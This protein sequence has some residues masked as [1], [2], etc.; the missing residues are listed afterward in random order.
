VTDEVR[1]EE[2]EATDEVSGW[3]RTSLTIAV[4]VTTLAIAGVGWLEVRAGSNS[5]SAAQESQQFSVKTMSSL[6]QSQETT[7]V[8]YEDF[9][10]AEQDREQAGNALQQGIFSGAGN[11]AL[12]AL[13]QQRFDTLATKTQALTPLTPNSTDG[14]GKDPTFP[15]HAFARATLGADE[16]QALQDESNARESAWE[17]RDAKYTAVLTLLAVALYLFGL[18]LAMPRRVFSIFGGVGAVLLAI[19]VGWSLLI[20][21]SAPKAIPESAAADYANGEIALETSTIGQDP[22]GFQTSIVD[23]TKAIDEWPSFARA[24]LGRAN[25]TLASS[26]QVQASLI[27]QASLERVVSDLD[28]ASASGLGSAL[29]LEQ[30]SGT[31]FSLALH[32]QDDLFGEAADAAREAIDDV[33][34]DPVPRYSLA[35]SLLGEGDTAGAESAYK[36]AIGRTLFLDEAGTKPRNSPQ[37]EE[38]WVSGALSD[39][40]ALRVAKPSLGTSIDRMKELVVG[41]VAAGKVVEPSGSAAFAGVKAQVLPAVVQWFTTGSSGYD[42]SKDTLSVQWYSRTS[43]NAWIGMPEVSGPI[44]AAV[45]T[46][47]PAFSA[48]NLT[49][50]SLPARCLG[51]GAYRVELYADGHLAG[52][53]TTTVKY[54]LPTPFIDRALNLEV[55]HPPDW[56]LAKSAL[57]GFRQGL[58]S[59]EGSEGVYL[60]RYDTT[61]LSPALRKLPI[62]QLTDSLLIS[63]MRSSAALFPS[64][65]IGGSAAQH[66]ASLALPGSTQRTFNYD[67]GYIYGQSS[68]DKKDGA[69]LVTLVFGPQSSF[70]QP[71]GDLLPVIASLAEYTYGGGAR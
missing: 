69:V 22:A 2:D 32:K 68:E 65:P 21:T 66:Q 52:S 6:L 40:E 70:A 39:L 49:S 57:P 48:R 13:V 45:E 59:P 7:K 35:V 43:G 18:G 56:K 9:L 53:A 63:T 26:P 61:L 30:L 50:S 23:F 8:D 46:N 12:L 31:D 27:P 25:A 1:D 41:S 42:R 67:G 60:I 19:G 47:A 58:V 29:T 3:V 55:C 15:R 34:T 20:V 17:S 51:T 10:Q 71:S 11:K 54:G 14:P 44:D 28:H 36:D 16:D 62:E 4:A 38:G 24:Y 37:V 5:D 64:A 33:P